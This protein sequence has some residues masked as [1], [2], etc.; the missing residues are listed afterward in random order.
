VSD[1]T[2]FFVSKH[3]SEGVD[4]LFMR[5][6]A[7]NPGATFDDFLIDALKPLDDALPAVVR[8]DKKSQKASTA[9][10]KAKKAAKALEG[11]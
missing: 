2:F 9:K 6:R 5:Y 4:D 1:R 10:K 11:A 8:A 3:T 7:V